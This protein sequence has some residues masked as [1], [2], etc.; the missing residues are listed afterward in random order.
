MSDNAHELT[1]VGYLL[2]PKN[3]K[4]LIASLNDT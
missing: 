2:L 3:F 1:R 4:I